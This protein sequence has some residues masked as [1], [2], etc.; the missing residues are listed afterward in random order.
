MDASKVA[1]CLGITLLLCHV[2]HLAQGQPDSC[3][4]PD[5][6]LM[7]PPG[8]VVMDTFIS[9]VYI[10]SKVNLFYFNTNI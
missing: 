9:K 3:T 1:K 8:A 10:L 5:S 4:K 7:L 6:A 2:T